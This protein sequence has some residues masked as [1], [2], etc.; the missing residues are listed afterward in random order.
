MGMLRLLL[1]LSVL[2][3]HAG[4]IAGYTMLGGPLA[5][6][7]FFIISGF[8]MGLV[9]NERYAVP[10]LDRAFYLNRALRI[11]GLYYA[12][13]ALH[14]AVFAALAALGYA[15]PLDVWFSPQLPFGQKVLLALLNLSVVGQDAVLWLR[16]GP[17]G[18]AWTAHFDGS[19]PGAG[20]HYMLIP[21]AWSLSLELVFYAIAPLIAR[22]SAVVVAALIAASLTVRALAAGAG[23]AFDPFDARFF[24]FELALF[25]A[26]VLA[27]KAYAAFPGLWTHTRWRALLPALP[28]AILA[29]PWLARGWPADTFF[30]PP[31][32]AL[33]MLTACSLPALHTLTRNWHRDRMVGELSYPVYLGHLLIVGLIA[34]SPLFA[35]APALL[36]LVAAILACGLAAVVVRTI[37]LPIERFR[38]ALAARAGAASI[39][40]GPQGGDSRVPL[41]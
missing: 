2:L 11:F 6:Q 35:R 7:C 30:T 4:G 18:L 17:H 39:G 24:P 37:D 38:R 29:W 23:W 3:A 36:P 25:L 33:L 5:V 9:L 40:T 16:V 20:F 15:T 27:Y 31:R 14:L 26:G 8:Y 41:A 10:A 12:F 19:D 34:G 1:A 32:V 21:A 13:L 28:L 22:R